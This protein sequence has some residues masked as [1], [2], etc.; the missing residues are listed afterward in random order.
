M[1]AIILFRF[2]LTSKKSLDNLLSGITPN[3]ISF[4]TIIRGDFW[5]LMHLINLSIS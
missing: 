4:V 3:P 2:P 5:T 1:L